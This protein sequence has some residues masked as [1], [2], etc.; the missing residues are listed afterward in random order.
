MFNPDDVLSCLEEVHPSPL[1]VGQIASELGV[2]KRHREAVK[3]TLD[4][5]VFSGRVKS[6]GKGKYAFASQ[7]TEEGKL[8]V[9]HR[10]YAFV[11]VS[12]GRSV[13]VHQEKQLDALDGD[14]VEISIWPSAKGW[15]GEVIRTVE[16]GRKQ[17]TGVVAR[18]RGDQAVIYPDD[19]RI[20]VDRILA[21][22]KKAEVGTCVVVNVERYPTAYDREIEGKVVS[23]L[24]APNDPDVETKKILVGGGIPLEFP[25]DVVAEAE[26]VPLTVGKSEMVDREDLRQLPFVTIDPITARDFD[27]ALY[28]EPTKSGYRVFVAVADVSY[29]VNP[30]THLDREAQNRGV[31][32]YLPDR[33]IPML[34]EALSA[35]ICSLNPEVD[36][37]AMVVKMDYTQDGERTSTD[38]C[39]AVIRSHARFAYEDVAEALYEDGG[40]NLGEYHE[41]V[42]SLAKIGR[43]ARKKRQANGSLNLELA[44]PKVVLDEDDGRTVREI[45]KSKKTQSVTNAYQ[46]VEEFMIA[47]NIA[48]GEFLS[49]RAPKVVWRVHEPPDQDRL[50]EVRP[51]LESF[52][53]PLDTELATT[54]IGLQ[55]VLNQVQTTDAKQALGFALLRSLKQA[56]Y[57]TTPLGHFG[58]A[59]RDYL[60]FTSP[61]RR[62]PDVTVHRL[63]K[64]V[65]KSERKPAG[66][67]KFNQP[68]V[69]E[70]DSA[71][72]FSSQLERRAVDA[73]RS[74]LAFY[75]ALYMRQ[76]V[77]ETYTGQVVGV[78]DFGIFIQVNE[79][80]VEGLL[81]YD[82]LGDERFTYDPVVRQAVG[83]ETTIKL[84]D[85]I[86]VELVEVNM[87]LRRLDFRRAGYIPSPTRGFQNSR[88]DGKRSSRK[89]Q[90]GPKSRERRGKGKKSRR[91]S[92]NTSKPNKSAKKGRKTTKK[93]KRR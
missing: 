88:K 3:K 25:S 36:R 62:Y 12:E 16:R 37:M 79:P 7:T 17:L 31:S 76:F 89:S 81:K 74:A 2:K 93:K 59:A 32:V 52:G 71:A 68:T 61:I 21:R 91:E 51:L 85:T 55:K 44:E 28:C 34:P 1:S 63:L 19:P 47:A 86:E 26:A 50:E 87:P 80:F 14:T 13:Y 42:A 46:L 10:G 9:H 38:F 33:V 58:L 64:R 27:D 40:N 69:E 23:I 77:G 29:Y 45:V 48:V 65:L 57:T 66:N 75:R 18:F 54:P 6:V 83:N 53:I 67:P 22:G 39:A 15:D 72:S 30:G 41:M 82:Q 90:K 20:S 35:G 24:G 84:G 8:I 56:C 49:K 70:L 4:E 43:Q 60:H 92:P 78:T 5:L 73:E 11:H